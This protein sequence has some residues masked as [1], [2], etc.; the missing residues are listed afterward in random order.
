MGHGAVHP[1]FDGIGSLS[2]DVLATTICAANVR[3]C[4]ARPSDEKD[5]SLEEEHDPIQP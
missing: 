5:V 2:L 1:I 3:Q 4:H